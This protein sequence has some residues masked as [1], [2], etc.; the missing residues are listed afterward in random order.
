MTTEQQLQAIIE[1]AE[2]NGYKRTYYLSTLD[3]NEIV[4][5]TTY[6]ILFSHEFAKAYFGE[7]EI[8]TE[9]GSN[10]VVTDR[11]GEWDCASCGRVLVQKW[12]Q[13]HLQQAVLEA[14]PIAYYYKFI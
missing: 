1:K 10:E 11:Y 9:C 14:D 4:M 13:Y 3:D 7:E 5:E 2:G 6:P 8:C 12:W